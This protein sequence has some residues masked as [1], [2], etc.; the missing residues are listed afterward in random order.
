MFERFTHAA[1]AVV[2]QA[3]EEAAALGHGRVDSEHLLLAVAAAGA[4]P[5]SLGIDQAGLRAAVEAAPAGLDA[6]ALAT[7]GIDMDNVRRS[8]EQ[9]FGPDALAARGGARRKGHVSF[10][11]GAKRAL[12]QSLREAVALRDRSIGPEHIL[13]GLT[14]DPGGGMEHVLAICGTSSAALRAAVLASRR[15]AA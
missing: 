15:A 14:S 13:L 7:I 3:H 9:S 10:G 4:L 8:V 2:A 5:A 11:P 12:E 1:R 6:Q